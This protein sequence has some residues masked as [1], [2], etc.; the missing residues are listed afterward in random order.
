MTK[1][2]KKKKKITITFVNFNRTETKSLYADK[3]ILDQT[4]TQGKTVASPAEH[5][6]QQCF[7]KLPVPEFF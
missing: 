3:L 2:K 6:F 5:L 4:H 1:K 7:T